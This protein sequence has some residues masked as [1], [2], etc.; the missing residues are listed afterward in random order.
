MS[1]RPE[2]KAD[3]DWEKRARELRWE[4][5]LVDAMSQEVL[6]GIS[7]TAR[8]SLL[9][10]ETPEGWKNADQLV[11]VLQLVAERADTLQD[12]ISATAERLG[13]SWID[14]AQRRRANAFNLGLPLPDD[15]PPGEGRPS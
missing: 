10:L 11:A 6:S 5:S 15:Q 3:A 2:E 1:E 9:A 12:Q 13:C 4:F 8:L 7:A 14:E